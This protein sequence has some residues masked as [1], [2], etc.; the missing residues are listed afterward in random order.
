MR[1]EAPPDKH[2]GRGE[3]GRRGGGQQKA[4]AAPPEPGF[5]RAARR[6]K[7]HR[8]AG[9]HP[10]TLSQSTPWEPISPLPARI[11]A[12]SR[13]LGATSQTRWRT[14]P[15]PSAPRPAH[16]RCRLPPIQVETHILR[17]AN[18]SAS[19]SAGLRCGWSCSPAPPPRAYLGRCGM[20]RRGLG[21]L[22]SASP[23]YSLPACA[24]IF[25]GIRGEPVRM[26]R[27]FPAS[28]S[29]TAAILE[30]S[31]PATLASP[32]PIIFTK[33]QKKKMELLETACFNL[34]I[35]TKSRSVCVHRSA[36]SKPTTAE[37]MNWLKVTNVTC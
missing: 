15:C 28:S 24:D 1:S 29:V 30:K 6:P 25:T 5:H 36:A 20:R 10:D 32:S 18:A 2:G 4:A 16:K 21:A 17:P 19:V 13:Y 14:R 33:F 22:V 26:R 8:D 35:V 37:T 23:L 3:N 27:R 12:S 7:T 31:A 34:K 9:F 11:A